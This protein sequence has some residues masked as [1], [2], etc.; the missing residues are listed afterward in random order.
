MWMFPKIWVPQ[1][2]HFDRF[3]HCKPSIL[4]YHKLWRP[5]CGVVHSWGSRDTLQAK[6]KAIFGAN[7]EVDRAKAFAEA[8]RVDAPP[9]MHQRCHDK[10]TTIGAIKIEFFLRLV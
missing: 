9:V 5:L 6:H 7:S 8:G 3:F 10:D 4:G 1:I 2:I